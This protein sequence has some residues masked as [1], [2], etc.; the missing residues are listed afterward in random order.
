MLVFVVSVKAMTYPQFAIGGPYEVVLI[1]TNKTDHN[2]NCRVYLK[3]G[4]D[5]T[6]P[7]PVSLNGEPLQSISS[8]KLLWGPRGTDKIVIS[9]GNDVKTGYIEILGADGY[10]ML[11]WTINYFYVYRENGA[12][13]ESIGVP[14]APVSKDYYLPVERSEDCNTAIA[15]APYGDSVPSTFNVQLTLYDDQGRLYAS[16]SM[17]FEGQMA[18]FFSELFNGIPTSF[19]G[20]L[21]LE[22]PYLF[23]FVGFR[24]VDSWNGPQFTAIEAATF[25]N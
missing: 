3:T 22:A 14:N 10:T 19:L 20:H 4:N 23:H 8:I 2:S 6:F 16:K 11:D 5:Q 7:Y 21:V 15:W 25:Q 13:L 18:S 12:V 1:A 9:G 24:M 17:R